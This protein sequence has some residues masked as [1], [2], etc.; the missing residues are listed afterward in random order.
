MKVKEL[1]YNPLFNTK[2]E[3][4]YT[5]LLQVQWKINGGNTFSETHKKMKLINDSEQVKTA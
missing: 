4:K 2:Y 1:V 5:N 3:F